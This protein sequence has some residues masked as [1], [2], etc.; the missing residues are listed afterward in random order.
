MQHSGH[1][2]TYIA[3]TYIWR[4]QISLRPWGQK[5]QFPLRLFAFIRGLDD[6]HGCRSTRQQRDSE[7]VGGG[8][9]PRQTGDNPT[10]PVIINLG[11]IGLIFCGRWDLRSWGCWYNWARG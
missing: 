5:L 1:L 11:Y 8:A 7:A 6:S 10:F 2:Y 3:R 9:G 4:C